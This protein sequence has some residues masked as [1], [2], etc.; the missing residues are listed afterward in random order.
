MRTTE[1]TLAF[2]TS[3]KSHEQMLLPYTFKRDALEGKSISCLELLRLLPGKRMV[4][5]AQYGE[6][7]VCIRVFY[8]KNFKN[9]WKLS[10]NRSRLLEEAGISTPLLIESACDEKQS[11]GIL[12]FEFIEDARTLNQIYNI[13]GAQ[14]DGKG[15]LKLA[16][17]N[18]AEMHNTFIYQKDLHLDNLLYSRGVLYMVDS[19][20][21]VK[22]RNTIYR[23]KNFRE[24]FAV[25]NLAL[26]FAQLYPWQD[27]SI[28]GLLNV[29]HAA[30]GD[31]HPK[32]S[33]QYIKSLVK[34]IRSSR[35][36]KYKKKTLR[37]CSEFD[38]IKNKRTF[39]VFTR[40]FG[41]ELANQ[42]I[43]NSDR[44]IRDGDVIKKSSS[45]TIAKIHIDGKAFVVKRYSEKNYLPRIV[46]RS[47]KSRAVSLWQLGHLLRL[48]GIPTATPA[49]VLEQKEGCFSVESY[50]VT[51][52]LHGM[53]LQEYLSKASAPSEA[54]EISQK[55]SQVLARL[56]QAAYAHGEV[57][58]ANIWIT[59]NTPVLIDLSGL[60][61]VHHNHVNF[62][63]S[64]NI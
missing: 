12:L 2:L 37:K 41:Y 8:G 9:R 29:Y 50:I 58:R 36:K 51:E 40:K 43:L 46:H 20:A 14:E 48:N 56:S 22:I 42:F 10:L 34:K 44:F 19:D 32:F 60:K 35:E 23:G 4:C 6:K 5:R 18:I 47:P 31:S 33:V 57:E 62:R 63:D 26:F 11:L 61:K 59:N 17:Q 52:Y 21:V 39:C 16:I 28:G 64:K 13:D 7:D 53:Y 38:V 45:T 27:E 30:R 1:D 49:L 54:E 3:I 55:I 24:K 25:K 15:I